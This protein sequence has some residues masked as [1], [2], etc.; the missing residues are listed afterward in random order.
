MKAIG[1][2]RRGA[3]EA[4]RDVTPRPL[5]P[6]GRARADYACMALLDAVRIVGAG[7]AIATWAMPTLEPSAER[8]A[9]GSRRGLP[10]VRP[11]ASPSA[12][13]S[14]W[15]PIEDGLRDAMAGKRC[16]AAATTAERLA[17]ARP[18]RASRRPRRASR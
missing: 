10:H 4:G 13:A 3:A 1:P 2:D 16:H 14:S 18:L 11:P 5:V 17:A 15:P 6:P 9:G 7:R 8:R 12:A